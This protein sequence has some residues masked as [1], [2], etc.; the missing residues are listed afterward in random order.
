MVVDELRIRCPGFLEYDKELHKTDLHGK[1]RN[2]NRLLLWGEDHFFGEA[3]KEDWFEAVI[4][5]SR[6]HP[7]DVRM[8]EYWADW[9]DRWREGTQA[10]Y[11]PFEEWRQ[12][13]DDYVVD[14][15]A[16]DEC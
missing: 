7:R 10:S 16:N 5:Y 14:P 4:L 2:W 8:V 3:K 6:R 11:P 15:S 1:P 9:C 13:A 12:A